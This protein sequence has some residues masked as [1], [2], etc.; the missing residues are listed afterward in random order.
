M[1]RFMWLILAALAILNVSGQSKNFTIEEAVVG[2]Y[3]QFAP[4][5]LRGLSWRG[6]SGFITWIEKNELHQ[7]T[8]KGQDKTTLLTLSELN[9]GRGEFMEDSMRYF[10]AVNWLDDVDFRFTY[11]GNNYWF[12]MKTRQISK[13]VT[14]PEGAE[15]VQ[16]S[17]K[18]DFAYTKEHNLFLLSHGKETAVTTDGKYGLVYGESVHRNE[19][20]IDGG[21]FWS[22]LGNLLA[23]YRMDESMVTDY[24][25]VDVTERVA[26]LNNI[27]YPMAGMTSHEVSLGVFNPATGKTVYLDIA[28]PKDQ[29]LTMITWSPDEKS[30]FVGVLNRGQN[31]LALNQYDASTGKYIRTV[32]EESHSKYVEPETGIT[33]LPNQPNRFLYQSE[34][35]G[36]NHLYLY[37]I[38]GELIRQVT[39]GS[40]EV[41]ELIGFDE[42]AQNVYVK[43]TRDD[44]K[45]RKI[46]KFNLNNDKSK[47]LTTRKGT[48][49]VIFNDNHS[50]FIAINNSVETPNLIEVY[51]E[52]GKLISELL[53]SK[54]PLQDYKMG[55]MTQFTIPSAD[56]KTMLECRMI[57]PVD[58]DS[59]KKYPAIIYV[60]G[61][62]HA[63]LVTDEWL[64]GGRLWE[65]YMAQKGYVLFTL[66]NRGSAHRGREFE[67]AIHRQCGVEEMKDQM[68]GVDYLLNT[69][70]VDENRIGVHGWS[71]GGFITISLLTSYPEIFK[72]GVAGGPVIDWKYYE[73]MYGERYM[74]TPQ[75]N[76][77]GYENTSLLSKAKNLK[78]DLL[79]IHGGVDNTV[80][81]QNSQQFLN[82]AIKAKKQVDYFIYPN[83]EHNVGGWDRVHLMEKVSL[84]F[85][86]HM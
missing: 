71:Y 15:G 29:Y 69:G 24:P 80:V 40:W 5:N 64:G 63:Q 62:P 38:S 27:K 44:A 14:I 55:Q 1:K 75:E 11:A 49:T 33:F 51:A 9:K 81:W 32:L 31:Q 74:D 72:A 21:I 47:I 79:I 42:K 76:P 13:K 77:E 53:R 67:N 18:D 4:E 19:F 83:H 25:L 68:Q 3:R 50:K 20:G 2:Q 17:D 45:Q 85:E 12:S 16:E 41:V 36:Y 66:D 37:D 28:G 39:K 73:V 23:F 26:K 61:G 78:A 6:A 84:Y 59:T 57:K 70:F 54:N 8:E 7:M 52:G 48:N 46:E 82:E 56:G 60:Y 86:D 22:P 43:T 35:D 34:K 10:P 58:F 65:Y 30:I